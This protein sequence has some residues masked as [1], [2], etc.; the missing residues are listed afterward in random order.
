M[1]K[2]RKSCGERKIMRHP[3]VLRCTGFKNRQK[4]EAVKVSCLDGMYTVPCN[5]II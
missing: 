5:T 4:S 2:P 3:F 1:Q